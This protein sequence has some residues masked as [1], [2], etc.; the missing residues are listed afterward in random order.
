MKL[1]VG[2]GNPGKEYEHTRHNVGFMII[3]Y[4]ATSYKLQA[5]SSTKLNADIFKGEIAQKRSILAKPQTYMNNSGQAVQ[6]ILAF[7]KLTPSDLIVI[8]DDK[9]IPLGETRVQ[10]DRGAAGHNGIKSIIEH[11]GTKDFVRIRV[12]IAPSPLRGGTGGGV[13]VD[14]A[15]FVLDNFSS[16]EQKILKDVFAHVVQEVENFVQL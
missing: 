6:A 10:R 12:G 3:D 4:L 14:T 16:D 2:L 13:V 5:T 8:H 7:Y 9:D 1:V 11:I 15:A